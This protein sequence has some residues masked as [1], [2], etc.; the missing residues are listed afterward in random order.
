M[1]SVLSTALYLPFGLRQSNRDSVMAALVQDLLCYETVWLL[2]DQMAAIGPLISECGVPALR[3]ALDEG[4]L[5]F[6][7]D[8]QIL[9]WPMKRGYTGP[10][11]VIPIVSVAGQGGFTQA[12]TRELVTHLAVA[13]GVR[14]AEARALAKAIDTATVDFGGMPGAGDPN[15]PTLLNGLI[16]QLAAYRDALQAQSGVALTARDLNH[17]MRDLRHQLRSPLN[18]RQ[19]RVARVMTKPGW[20]AL[21]EGQPI[22]KKQFEL[23]NMFLADRTLAVLGESQ[24]DALLHTDPSVERVLSTRLVRVRQAASP[25]LDDV[26]HASEV[27]LPII[28]ERTGLA[29]EALLDARNSKAGRAFREQVVAVRDQVPDLEL[30]QAYQRTLR[31]RLGDR[32]AVRAARFLV[33]SMVGIVPGLGTAV[34]ALDAF[35]VDRLLSRREP[36]FFIDDTL[37]KLATQS[38]RE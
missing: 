2:T 21:E 34:S 16:E 17:L 1:S 36:S 24:L 8:R 15:G 3:R 26:L 12:D 22:S 29:F 35:L 20:E 30:I 10:V 13:T 6:V 14:I 37:R 19:H 28:E 38:R 27:P 33:T 31:E 5:H 23:L 18:T 25:E 32:F 4:V 11:P 9:S 7:H